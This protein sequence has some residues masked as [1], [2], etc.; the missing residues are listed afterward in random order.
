MLAKGYALYK[1]KVL[2]TSVRH[3]TL[4]GFRLK[5]GARF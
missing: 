3:A 5:P 2:K 4:R 1:L